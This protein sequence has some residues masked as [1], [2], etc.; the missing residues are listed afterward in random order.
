LRKQCRN[1]FGAVAGVRREDFVRSV[2]GLSELDR[3][4]DGVADGSLRDH[5]ADRSRSVWRRDSGEPQ[6]GEEE[7][8]AVLRLGFAFG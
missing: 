2:T 8:R 4:R 1:G 3:E 6:S 7:V 5:G